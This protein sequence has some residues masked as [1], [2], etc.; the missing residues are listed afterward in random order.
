MVVHPLQ[1]PRFPLSGTCAIARGRVQTLQ[2]HSEGSRDFHRRPFRLSCV[3]LLGRF[4][5]RR[6]F[7]ENRIYAMI[8]HQNNTATVEMGRDKER[9]TFRHQTLGTYTRSR[10]DEQWLE[11]LAQFDRY[12]ATFTNHCAQQRM[13]GGSLRVVNHRRV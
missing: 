11:S 4:Q 1:M 10:V 8:A 3:H 9:A 7:R 5:H 12:F 13:S 2:V 6:T